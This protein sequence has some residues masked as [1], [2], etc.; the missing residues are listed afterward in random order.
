M[1]DKI[2]VEDSQ[3]SRYQE[4]LLNVPQ[5]K[6]FNPIPK[7]RLQALLHYNFD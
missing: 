1:R 7:E 4:C 5:D 3:M 6:E 2:H